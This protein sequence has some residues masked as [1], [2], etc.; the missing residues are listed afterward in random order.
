MIMPFVFP[1]LV[2]CCTASYGVAWLR[3]RSTGTFHLLPDRRPLFLLTTAALIFAICRV[4][5]LFTA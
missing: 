4:I 3:F 2:A 1:A 5:E